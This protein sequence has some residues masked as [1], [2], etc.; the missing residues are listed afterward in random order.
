MNRHDVL[1]WVCVGLCLFD[2]VLA[3]VCNGIPELRHYTRLF[4]LCGFMSAV[5]VVANYMNIKQSKET[6]KGK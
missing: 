6:P 2:V 3:T 5:G 1:F 4:L